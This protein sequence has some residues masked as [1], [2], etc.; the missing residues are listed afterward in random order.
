MDKKHERFDQFDLSP[1]VL[2]AIEDVGYEEPTPIQDRTIERLLTGIDI[3][4][5]AQTGTGKTAAFA[6]PI[7]EQL[8]VNEKSVGAIVLAPT[9]EL[10]VQAAEEFNRLGAVKGIHTLPVYGGTSIE[11][12]ID[13]LERGVHV[14][15]GTPGRVLDHLRRGT[16]KLGKVRIVVLDEA[17][18]M[19]DMG[20]IEDITSI[21][22]A[23]PKKRQTMLFSATIPNGVLSIAQRYQTDPETIKIK[24][25]AMTAPNITQVYYEVDFT[26]KVEAISRLI[27]VAEEGKF[28][29]FCG[30]KR[31]CDDLTYKLNMR[32]YASEAMHGDFSQAQREKV[33]ADFKENRADLLIAT[34]VAA[35]GLDIT[36]ISHV[37]NYSIPQDPETYVHRIGRTGR[38]GREGDAVTLVTPREK[39]QLKVIM[40][41]SN[42]TITKGKLPT[43]VDMLESR[44]PEL[45]ERIKTVSET[46]GFDNYMALSER[47]VEGRDSK[48]ILAALLRIVLDKPVVAT[49]GAGGAVAKGNRVKL[50]IS[51]GL[52]HKADAH[53]VITAVCE[54]TGLAK[55]EIAEV[56]LFDTHT[57]I[58]VPTAKA[59]KVIEALNNSTIS[60]KKVLVEKARTSPGGGGGGGK[61]GRPPR[62]DGGGGRGGRPG[63]GGRP[64]RRR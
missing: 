62:R 60:E 22:E 44:L 48:E 33:L 5:R 34:D 7:I 54:T 21:L 25:E 51:V 11:R 9:R 46:M 3:I 13:A 40:K 63:G 17:D 52:T 50:F 24:S 53:S 8:D 59:D 47:L 2:K 45:K 16:L 43:R 37:V 18:E 28:L 38:A 32:G 41:V 42:A 15:V 36:D 58:K 39:L 31:E 12:Q 27:D 23:T 26:Q 56:E 64:P 10:A 20:F 19:L 4:G 55:D 57:Y 14:I 6:I 49:K 30:T 35:R 29:I 61:G 1:E